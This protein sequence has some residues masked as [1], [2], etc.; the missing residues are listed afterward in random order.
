MSLKTVIIIPARYQSSRLPGK[1]LI[2]INGKPMIQHVVEAAY[3][4]K[5]VDEVY[6]ATDDQRILEV[7]EGLGYKALMTD[8][9]HP[10][11]TDRLIEVSQKIKADIYINLQGDEP[12]INVEDVGKLVTLI[13]NNPKIDCASMCHP[14]TEEEA[15]NPN[16]VKVV[17]GK[18]KKALYFSRSRIPYKRE[19]TALP[20]YKHIGVYAYRSNLLADYP[21][22]ENSSLELTESLEQLRLLSNDV[23]IHMMEVEFAY[24][25]VD[26]EENIHYLL[27]I[28]NYKNPE[29]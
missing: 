22:V 5:G 2:D 19:E 20:Y 29:I 11:G 3:K 8:K 6:V 28:M 1:P 9:N 7:V 4:V 24:P 14:I 27:N 17:L 18:G 13:K 16:S 15:N 12:L 10:S 23:D 21:K 26:T 25:G